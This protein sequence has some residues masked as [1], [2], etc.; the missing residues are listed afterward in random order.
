MATLDL[1]AIVLALFGGMALVFGALERREERRIL[2]RA[3]TVLAREGCT[4]VLDDG[5]AEPHPV[6]LADAA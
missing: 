6:A 3:E 1:A 4:L 5:D 2:A